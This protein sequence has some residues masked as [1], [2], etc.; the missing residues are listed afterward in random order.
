MVAHIDF[1][2]QH[3]FGFFVSFQHDHAQSMV[4]MIGDPRIH[5]LYSSIMHCLDPH[6]EDLSDDGPQKS[7]ST[8]EGPGPVASSTE[9]DFDFCDP[10]SLWSSTTSF[11]TQPAAPTS[12]TTFQAIAS[13]AA[14]RAITFPTAFPATT[15][16][17]MMSYKQFIQELE[18]DILPYEAER[19][20]IRQYIS[21]QKRTYFNAHKDEEWLKNKYH[22]TNLVS[23][24]ER[25]NELARKLAK[26]FHLV[27]Q[28]GTLDL[29]PAFNPA[30]TKEERTSEPNSDDETDV[31]G[32]RR[33]IQ[34]FMIPGASRLILNKRKLLFESWT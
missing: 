20:N 19:R 16:N 11:P 25:R 10:S 33:L 32:K 2:Q 6:F 26:Y 21:T 23:V 34:S 4:A 15:A 9:V 17:G 31:G 30:S 13:T 1:V 14:F 8:F 5:Q 12:P 7:K 28:S 22:P 18:D 27:L 3:G 29:D 24:I